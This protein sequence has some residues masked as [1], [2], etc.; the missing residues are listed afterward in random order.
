MAIVLHKLEKDGKTLYR[1][2][3]PGIETYGSK[4]MT[5]EDLDKYLL[6]HALDSAISG[7]RSREANRPLAKTAKL[8]ESWPKFVEDD[9]EEAIADEALMHPFW[10]E[11]YLTARLAE[12]AVEAIMA[13]LAKQKK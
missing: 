2:F 3:N 1:V 11:F 5:A 12:I 8:V 6:F 10:V 9:G 7:H 13:E 4:E